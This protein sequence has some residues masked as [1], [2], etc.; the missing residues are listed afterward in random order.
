MSRS[1]LG[2]T[3]P[4]LNSARVVNGWPRHRIG[5]PDHL[6]QCRDFSC[7]AR[8]ETTPDQPDACRPDEFRSVGIFR[9]KMRARLDRLRDETLIVLPANFLGTVGK[10]ALFNHI[11]SVVLTVWHPESFVRAA[12]DMGNSF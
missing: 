11:N 9:M 2:T 3:R 1:P 8:I 10:Q 6:L 5:P 12:A 4:R 7:P